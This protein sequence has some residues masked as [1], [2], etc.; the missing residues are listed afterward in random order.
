MFLPIPAID[1]M[2]GQVVRLSRGLATERTVYSDDP[3]A[4][5]RQFTA[6][7]AVRFPLSGRFTPKADHSSVDNV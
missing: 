4:F 1:L 5:A 3:A 2:D 7:G 6:D